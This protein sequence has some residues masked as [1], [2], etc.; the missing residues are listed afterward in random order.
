MSDSLEAMVARIDERTEHMET[1]IKE[2]KAKCNS[3]SDTVGRHSTQLAAIETTI[4]NNGRCAPTLSTKQKAGV[5]A[6][7]VGLITAA[8]AGLIEYFRHR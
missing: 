2:V 1:D 8:I 7:V 6:T 5:G 4:K 3:L